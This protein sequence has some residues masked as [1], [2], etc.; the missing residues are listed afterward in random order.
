[1]KIQVEKW[2]FD[3]EK[4]YKIIQAEKCC[5]KILNSEVIVLNDDYENGDDS[6]YG[7]KLEK[8]EHYWDYEDE[9]NQ[10]TYEPIKYCPYC[11]E[12]IE[13][14]IVNTIDKTKEYLELIKRR[15]E[16]WNKAIK[17]DSRKKSDKLREESYALDK[18][19]NELY[20]SD[21]LDNINNK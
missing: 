17:T 14:S 6:D 13:I 9:I 18:V 21:G 10:Y 4:S 20:Y 19:I 3:G 16:L 7:V 8:Y 1:M 2:T 5:D 11:G 12:K 15:E